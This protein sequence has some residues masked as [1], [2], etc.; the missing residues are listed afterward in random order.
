MSEPRRVIA[1]FAKAA[2]PGSVKTRLVPPLSAEEAAEL[3]LVFLLDTTDAM[4]RAADRCNAQAVVFYSPAE[5]TPWFRSL[6]GERVQLYP[7]TDGSLTERLTGAYFSL[8]EA[9]YD[10]VCFIGADSPT[11]PEG[12]IDAAFTE[13][14]NHDLAIGPAQDGGYYLIAMRAANVEIFSD[15]SWSTKSVLQQTKDTARRLKLCVKLLPTWFDVD[16][17]SSLRQLITE[18]AK[19]Q[20]R[21]VTLDAPKTRAYLAT[22][23]LL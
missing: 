19:C 8:A 4:L 12:T 16:D 23:P 11:L 15:I 21:E 7:Q 3:A 6:L 18:L 22:H 17:E 9:G 2:I 13:L 5:A 20:P 14:S 10:A 1:L